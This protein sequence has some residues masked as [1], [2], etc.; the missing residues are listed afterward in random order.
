M[1][2]GLQG[3]SYT[4]TQKTIAGYTYDSVD[5][6]V[7]GTMEASDIIVTYYYK[8]NSDVIVKYVDEKYIQKNDIRLGDGVFVLDCDNPRD[9]E[10]IKSLDNGLFVKR[11]YKN[12][13]IQRFCTAR[14]TGKRLLFSSSTTMAEEQ[15]VIKNGSIISI[16]IT[17]IYYRTIILQSF[18]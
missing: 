13:D 17:N 3:D 6:A 8:K 1:I 10:T 16:G 7:S 18:Y 4:T 15:A 9:R 12:S 2:T 14:S 5:G 11:F